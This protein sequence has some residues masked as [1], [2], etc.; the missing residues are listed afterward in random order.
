M[1]SKQD[2]YSEIRKWN[3]YEVA[4]S[5]CLKLSLKPLSGKIELILSTIL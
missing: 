2:K 1:S 5:W 3:K 4:T